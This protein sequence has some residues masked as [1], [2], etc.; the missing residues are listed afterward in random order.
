M[1]A[2]GIP[3]SLPE[4]EKFDALAGQCWRDPHG[5]MRPLHAMNPA[6]TA[7]VAERIA[8]HAGRAGTN[9]SG[10]SV[11][12]V[13]CGAGLASEAFARFGATVTG[14]DAA[15]AARAAARAHADSA[16]LP[17]RYLPGGPEDLPVGERFDAV[18][19]L[20]VIEHVATDDRPAFAAALVRAVKPGGIVFLSTLNRT[21][22]SYLTAKLGAEY[23]LRLLPVGTHDW[24]LFVTPAELG[25]LLRDAGLRV[26]DIA[27]LE[28][29][30][31]SGAWRISRDVSVN[32]LIAAEA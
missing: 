9:L 32:Y 29:G 2:L 11:L 14:M 27:G 20:E 21:P 3:R 26:A 10:L 30:K 25:T 22:K 12:D 5:P 13:G 15:P 16:G 18:V 8:R 23:V 1:A 4:V 28:M 31:C 17:I 6:R 7:W 24:K 19:S